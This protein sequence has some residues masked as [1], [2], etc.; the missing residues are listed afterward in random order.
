MIPVSTPTG[1]S[2]PLS[3]TR[4][5][6]STHIK[7][8]APIS[9]ERGT[10]FLWS[11][12]TSIRTQWGITSPTKPIIPAAYTNTPTIAAQTTKYT[13]RHTCKLVPSVIA[14]SSPYSI[15]FKVRYCVRKNTK[16]ASTTDKTT[17]FVVQSAPLKLPSNQ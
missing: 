8:I 9:A 11:V 12:P 2:F 7:K 4:Q 15:K 13:W 14:V 10:T 1:S 5:Q 6:T 17:R 3:S 16:P